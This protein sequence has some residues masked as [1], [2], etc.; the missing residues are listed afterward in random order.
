MPKALIIYYS[1]TG[2]T[3]SM[4][5]AVAEGVKS[6]GLSTRVKRVDYTTAY[7]LMSADAIAFG[8]PCYFGY[9]AGT[10]KEFFDRMLQGT[11]L[12]NLERKPAVAFVSNGERDG[13]KDALLSIE[14]MMAYFLLQK[15]AD[16]V[17][18]R[19]KPGSVKIEECKKLG[20]ALAQAVKQRKVKGHKK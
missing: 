19:G 10:M 13:G 1:R 11:I 4:A 9:M 6:K 14:N 8:S 17:I 15:A 20:V 12:K 2:N 7:D 18:S 3:E 5:K 16:G